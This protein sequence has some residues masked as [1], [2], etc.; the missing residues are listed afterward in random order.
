MKSTA[1][2]FLNKKRRIC[3]QWREWNEFEKVKHSFDLSN[4]KGKNCFDTL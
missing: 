4:F 2:G 3:E 1:L